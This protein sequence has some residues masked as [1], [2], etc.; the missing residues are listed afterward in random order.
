V[1]IISIKPDKSLLLGRL[2]LV[3]YLLMA[4][5]DRKFGERRAETSGQ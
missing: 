5:Y 4:F 2:T 1:E 3:Q